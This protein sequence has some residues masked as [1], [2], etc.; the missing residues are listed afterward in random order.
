LL[1]RLGVLFLLLEPALAIDRGLLF[2]PFLFDLLLA[3]LALG[4]GLASDLLFL[5]LL[6]FLFRRA[7]GVDRPQLC[8]ARSACSRSSRAISFCA[9]SAFLRSSDDIAGSA[10]GAGATATA[11]A[12]GATDATG[13]FGATVAFGALLTTVRCGP[14]GEF[15]ATPRECRRGHRD[16]FRRRP[17]GT[18]PPGPGRF[19]VTPG[20]S[21][22]TMCGVIMMTS[23]VFCFWYAWLRNR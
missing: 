20:E 21:R 6:L 5:L 1:L 15:G 7:L 9:R 10:T 12:T 19:G 18:V 4:V 16:R 3:R 17:P 14:A 2:E 11:G 8:G 13:A 23:S 22:R